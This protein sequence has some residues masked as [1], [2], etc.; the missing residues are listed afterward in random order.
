MRNHL[1]AA[2]VL[3]GTAFLLAGCVS[4]TPTVDARHGQS[5]TTLK[6]TQTRDPAA[7]VS[8]ASRSADVVDGR[9]ASNTMERYYQS[10]SVP[11]A[12]MNIINIGV[13]AGAASR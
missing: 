1:S 3:A 8:N 5:L 12:P 6:A 4:T 2:L 9:V 7:A 11:P 10:F 13:P